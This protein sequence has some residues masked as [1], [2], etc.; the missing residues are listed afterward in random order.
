M[1]L[2]Q[3]DQA[4]FE[5]DGFVI[6]RGVFTPEDLQPLKDE[7]DAALDQRAERL[8]ADGTITDTHAGAPFERRFA[9]L[10]AQSEEIQAGFDIPQLLGRAMFAQLRHPKLMDRIE[11]LLGGEISCSPIQHLRA[12]PPADMGGGRSYFNVPWHQDSAVTV[13]ECDAVRMLTCWY[14]IGE[15]TEEMGCMRLLPGVHTRGHIPH[16]A[17]PTGTTVHPDLLPDVEPV[18]AACGPGD[19]VVMSQFVPHHSTPNRSDR[20]R[21]SLDLRYFPTGE[22]NGRPWM[23]DFVV[24]SRR[25]PASELRDYEEWCR[26]WREDCGEPSAPTHRVVEAES[27]RG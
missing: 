2:N 21:W 12:K 3:D 27:L 16:V 22:T 7:I 15:A 6:L 9:L 20:C 10:M 25:D 14:P 11:P 19:V 4:A 13:P 18:I 26:R 23:P 5:R 17:G 8:L 24:R 1:A